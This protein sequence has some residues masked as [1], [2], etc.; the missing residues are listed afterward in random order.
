MGID[1]VGES[2]KKKVV[3]NTTAFGSISHEIAELRSLLFFTQEKNQHLEELLSLEKSMNR[4][5]EDYL[6]DTLGPKSM[7]HLRKKSANEQVFE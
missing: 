7:L 3:L 4:C 6:R 5:L 2:G 1:K